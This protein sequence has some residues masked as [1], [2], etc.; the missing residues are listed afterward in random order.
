VVLIASPQRRVINRSVSYEQ[1]D[2][3][4]LGAETYH[5]RQYPRD[6]EE[7]QAEEESW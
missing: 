2:H 1:S 5:M 7:R 6:D 4:F 3:H